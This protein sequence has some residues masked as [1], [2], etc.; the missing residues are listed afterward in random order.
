MDPSGDFCLIRNS[1]ASSNINLI[2]NKNEEPTLHTF[3]EELV[4]SPRSRKIEA[5]NFPQKEEKGRNINVPYISKPA[6]AEK[7][8]SIFSDVA[9]VL[10]NVDALFNFTKNGASYIAPQD[11]K[12]FSYAILSSNNSNIFNVVNK[13]NKGLESWKFV[14]YLQ[15]RLPLARGYI[16]NDFNWKNLNV[17]SQI[18]EPSEEGSG[19]LKNINTNNLDFSSDLLYPLRMKPDGM[20]LVIY[21]TT[22]KEEYS[23]KNALKILGIGGTLLYRIKDNDTNIRELY[24]LAM[25]FN[26]FSLFKPLSD[27]QNYSFIIA[28]D[29]RGPWDSSLSFNIETFLKPSLQFTTFIMKYVEQILKSP[30]TTQNLQYDLYKCKALWNIF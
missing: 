6:L 11:T 25:C 18:Q 2:N 7:I 30:Q 8:D 23:W 27:D 14:Q 10:A 1:F 3:S 20:D 28:E 21:N 16:L 5:S 9:I 13:E 12:E 29:Y 4:G 22:H 15:Y 19:Y 26:K 17:P 24:N